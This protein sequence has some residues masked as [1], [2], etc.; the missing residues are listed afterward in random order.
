MFDINPSKANFNESKNKHRTF[1][2][3]F[4]HL[5]KLITRMDE[6]KLIENITVDQRHDFTT[7]LFAGGELCEDVDDVDDDEDA[8]RSIVVDVSS[9]SGFVF[10]R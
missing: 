7:R 8:R 10:D 2:F 9:N 3:H 1:H 5:A 4:Y 6:T